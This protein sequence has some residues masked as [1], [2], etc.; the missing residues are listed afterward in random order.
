[1]SL[2]WPSLVFET[3]SYPVAQTSL[4]L[5]VILLPQLSP[6]AGITGTKCH[7]QACSVCLSTEGLDVPVMLDLTKNANTPTG[8]LMF[9]ANK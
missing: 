8:L 9:A 6:K 4:E 2:L 3:V 7:T 1:M 5:M